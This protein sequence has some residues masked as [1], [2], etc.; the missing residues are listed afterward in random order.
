MV[1]SNPLLNGAQIRALLFQPILVP[2]ALA[3]SS[4]LHLLSPPPPLLSN[5]PRK[6]LVSP[7]ITSS[8]N[9][10]DPEHAGSVTAPANHSQ[11]SASGPAAAGLLCFT[12]RHISPSPCCWPCQNLIDRLEEGRKKKKKTD[13]GVR[14]STL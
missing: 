6:R 2:R 8:R 5:C 7:S 9:P 4:I 14:F 3:I 11:A 12:T 13:S 10:S 1:K